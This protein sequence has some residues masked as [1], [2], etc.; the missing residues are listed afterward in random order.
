M[1]V[2]QIKEL[3]HANLPYP[4]RYDQL[5]FYYDETNN[6]RRLKLSEMG[7]NAPADRVFTLAGIVLKL[8]QYVS[9]WDAVRSAMRIQASAQ[10]V[11]YKHVADSDFLKSLD[12]GRLGIFLNWLY[13]QKI[14]IY[15]SVMDMHYWSIVDIIDSLFPVNPEFV[16]SAHREL[17]NELRAVL[18]ADPEEFYE[19]LHSYGYP[20]IDKNR[21]NE[22]VRDLRGIVASAFSEHRSVVFTMLIQLLKQASRNDDLELCFLHDEDEGE[23]IRDFSGN[24]LQPMYVYPRSRHIFDQETY[25][26]KVLEKLKLVDGTHQVDYSFSDSKK[27]IEIQMADVLA[28]FVGRYFTFLTSSSASTLVSVKE[29]L[30]ANQKLN[31]STFNRLI[32][33]SNVFSEGLLHAVLPLDTMWKHDFF[34]LGK[35]LPEHLL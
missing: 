27:C 23:L 32:D 31:L 1:E 28:G 12:S 3:P 25:V 16:S 20:D 21:A 13:D 29:T 4:H 35:D 9:G 2:L 17:K 7:L 5:K 11:K 26:S 33:R 10:E 30:T 24:F 15:Y 18:E 14:M 8:G 19:F 34:L 6:I 22:F